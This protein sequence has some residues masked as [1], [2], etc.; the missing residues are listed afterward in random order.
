MAKSRDPSVRTPLAACCVTDPCLDIVGLVD[1]TLTSVAVLLI[2]KVFQFDDH[3]F[4]NYYRSQ[5]QLS[6]YQ[7]NCLLQT[8]KTQLNLNPSCSTHFFTTACVMLVTIPRQHKY[9]SWNRSSHDVTQLY[10]YKLFYS[11][12]STFEGVLRTL[13]I[14]ISYKQSL[15]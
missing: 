8:V 9:F 6:C 3:C 7:L 5:T 10:Q 4:K 12:G 13:K 14:H 15:Y 1:T 2:C 11:P